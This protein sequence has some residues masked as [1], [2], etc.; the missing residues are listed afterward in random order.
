MSDV[1]ESSG[2]VL[3]VAETFGRRFVLERGGATDAEFL[4]AVRPHAPAGFATVLEG[5]DVVPELIGSQALA[6]FE[7]PLAPRAVS[8]VH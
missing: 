1:Q 7:W 6:P 2:P 4:C 5:C 8:V 3:E